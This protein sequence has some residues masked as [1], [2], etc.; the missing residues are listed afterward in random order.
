MPDILSSM[1]KDTTSEHRTHLFDLNCKICTGKC[2]GATEGQGYIHSVDGLLLLFIKPITLAVFFK[3]IPL[4]QKTED[5]PAAKK[6]KLTKKPETKPLRQEL[7]SSRSGDVQAAGQQQVPASL[8]Y[9]NPVAT[10]YQTNMDQALAE[11]Q[12]QLYQDVMLAPP[13]PAP[14][15]APAPVAPTVSSVSITRRDPRMARHGS[16]V[17]V[18]YAA[19]EKPVNSSAEALPVPVAVPVEVVPKL[20]LPMPPAPPAPVSKPTKTRCFISSQLNHITR[21]C[22]NLWCVNLGRIR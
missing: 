17:T 21:H 18:T 9:Q 13:V 10:S 19:P 20:P 22:L 12:A 6:A 15:P 11:S 16:G 8:A 3:M 2:Q 5:E 14:A 4:G 1:L 7:H